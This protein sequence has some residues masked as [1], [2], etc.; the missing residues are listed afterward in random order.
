MSH[1]R[2]SAFC[3]VL[4]LASGIAMAQ[5]AGGGSIQG[6]ITDPSGAVVPGATVTA[7]NIATG[8][9]TVRQTT[10]AGFFVLTPLPAGEYRVLVTAPGFQGLRQERVV[11]EALATVG[12]NLQLQLGSATQQVTVEE[13]ATMLHTDD[14]TLGGSMQNVVYQALPLAMSGVPRDPTQFIGLIPG[15]GAV[16][17]QAAGP[18]FATFNGAKEEMNEIYVEGLPLTFPAQQGDTRNLALGVSV[19]AVDQFQGETNSIKAMYQ[20]QGMENYV[21]K[22]GTNQFHGG[23]FEYFR[24]TALDARGFFSPYTPVEHQNEFGGTIGGPIKKDKIFFF[25][26]YDGYYFKTALPPQLQSVPS[27]TARTGDFTAYPTTIYDPQTT[28]CVGAICSKQPFPGNSIPTSRISSVSKS[29]QSYLPNPTNSNI[30]SNYLA[31]L[32]QA[33]HNNNTTDKVDLNLSDKHRLY[34]MFTRGKYSTDWTGSLSV[35]G[36]ALPLPYTNG[37]IVQEMPTLAQIHETWM[38]SPTVVNSFGFGFARLWIPIISSTAGGQYPIKAGLTGLPPGQAS[39]SFPVVNFN[40]PNAPI[41]WGGNTST[42]FNEA[43]NTFTLQDS[44][45]WVHGTHAVTAGFQLQRL[46]DNIQS[47]NTGTSA[48]FTFTNND[49][50]GFSP[51]G[52]LLTTTGNAYASY[53]LGAVNAAS[54]RQNSV[55]EVGSRFRDYS[56]FIQDDWKASSRLTLNVGL[57]YDILGPYHEVKDRVSFMNPNKPNAAAGGRLGALEFAGTGPHSCNCRIPIRTHFLNLGPRIG[58]AYRIGNKMVVRSGFSMMFNHGAAGV[59]GLTPGAAPGTAGYNASAAFTSP[60]TGQPSFYWDNGV[61]AYQRTPFIDPTYG[62]GFTTASPTTAVSLPYVDPSLAGHPP[63][64][65]NWHFGLQREIS[66]NLTV[67]GAYSASV[68]HFLPGAGSVGKWNNSMPVNYLALGSLLNAQAT[69]ANVAAAQA[70]MPGVALPFSN[71]QGTIAQMLKPYPQ[72]SGVSYFSGDLGNSTYNSFQLTVDRRFAGGLTFHLGYTFSK[73]IDN[74]TS[75]VQLGTGGGSR[76]PYNGKLDKGLGAIDHRHVLTA[77]AVYA[78]PF[79]KGHLLG[80]AHPF[81]RSIVSGWMV[82]GLVTANSGAPMAI[83]GSGCTTPGITGACFASYN[84]AFSGPVRINGNYG[85][86]N[87]LGT[88]ALSYLNKSAFMDPAPYT[89]GNLPESAPFGLLAP[90]RVNEDV[91]LRREF[92]IR[93][94]VKLALQGDAFNVFNTV[95]FAAPGTNIDSANFGQIISQSNAPRKLQIVARITF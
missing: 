88:G 84:P 82:S 43:E 34:G 36:D 89:F 52:S 17:T 49:T 93:E 8:V 66:A 11:V 44:I 25:G 67:G 31:I 39:D 65:I 85:S 94:R 3:I 53:L 9:D 71:F 30:V 86:G 62:T 63:Y 59:G 80:N 42:A 55:A 72:Y 41:Q 20:G 76:D 26:S 87:A 27:L 35:G 28:T 16:I 92:S 29:L 45:Q 90:H 69:P 23:L 33:L 15:V 37:R 68:G 81:V 47:P 75:T 19:E 74:V 79:G 60:A 57:R 50:A 24:N 77:T 58:L 46:Q 48:N 78:L 54:V 1:F 73:E 56:A 40:G 10:A 7:E 2:V 5:V 38:I 12:L 21:L 83:V 70:I 64:Y 13:S 91:S 6:T 51:T 4:V 95:F 22:S 32:P 61:P 14:A 18:S